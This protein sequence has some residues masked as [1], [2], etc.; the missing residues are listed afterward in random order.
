MSNKALTIGSDLITLAEARQQCYIPTTDTDTT[1]TAL[2]TLFI[3]AAQK[4]AENRTW[5]TL[6]E[7][8]WEYKLDAF[9]E[10]IE[11]SKAPVISID[12]IEYVDGDGVTQTLS[13]SLYQVDTDSDPS[14]IRPIDSFP[15]TKEQ[16]NAVIITYTAGYDG[17]VGRVLP[18]DIKVAIL[19]MIKYWY[20]NRDTVLISEKTAT[21]LEVP[22]GT[23]H[24]LDI[25]SRRVFA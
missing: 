20:D 12:S 21:A 25:N 9:P 16:Y 4:Y 14:R 8:Q 24:L 13:S 2:L 17:D 5:L 6:P 3:S 23:D 10:T 22:F 1:T 7:T 11:L 18:K 15:S 19:M